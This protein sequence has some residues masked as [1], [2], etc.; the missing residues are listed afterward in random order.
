MLLNI[1][2]VVKS[3]KMRFAAGASPQ[4][5]VD[6]RYSTPTMESENAIVLVYS[7]LNFVLSCRVEPCES[8]QPEQRH[9]CTICENFRVEGR[10]ILLY[11]TMKSTKICCN[12]KIILF[13]IHY[14]K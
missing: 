11:Y 14:V 9:S 8:R 1:R 6:S 13:D 2:I 5:R 3:Q 10:I 4:T 12:T 7:L